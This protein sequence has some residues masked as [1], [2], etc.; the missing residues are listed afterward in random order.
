MVKWSLSLLNTKVAF[1]MITRR[2]GE[3]DGRHTNQ[4]VE[5]ADDEANFSYV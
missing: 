1:K 4:Y 5:G 3:N 2:Q